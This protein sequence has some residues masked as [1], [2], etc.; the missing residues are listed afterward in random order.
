VDR[1]PDDAW[2]QLTCSQDQQLVFGTWTRLDQHGR[3]KVR[4]GPTTSWTS[5]GASCAAEVGW[6]SSNGRWRVEAVAPFGAAG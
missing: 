5:G 6:F 1:P 4:L 3:T 2:V